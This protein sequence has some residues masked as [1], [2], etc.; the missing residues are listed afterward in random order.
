MQHQVQLVV[1]NSISTVKRWDI[2]QTPSW[3]DIGKQPHFFE[4]CAKLT[5]HLQILHNAF[6]HSIANLQ[7]KQLEVWETL[8]GDQME[9]EDAVLDDFFVGGQQCNFG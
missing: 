2:V 4:L 8:L 5:T 7:A 1:E 9:I 3:G 6:P